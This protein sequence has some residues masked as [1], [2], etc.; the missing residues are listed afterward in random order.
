MKGNPTILDCKII[1]RMVQ[2][3]TFSG[4]TKSHIIIEQSYPSVITKKISLGNDLFVTSSI[5]D[6]TR[7][8]ATHP[9]TK[10]AW[11]LTD[12]TNTG[13]GVDQATDNK[14]SNLNKLNVSCRVNDTGI[15]TIVAPANIEQLATSPSGNTITDLGT[16][17]AN[18][19]ID[20]TPSVT[21]TGIPAGNLYPIGTT[22]ITYTV[23][24]FAGNVGVPAIQ[25]VTI[26]DPAPTT[27]RLR[28][29]PGTYENDIFTVAGELINDD[30]GKG[31]PGQTVTFEGTGIGVVSTNPTSPLPDAITSGFTVT[32]PLGIQIDEVSSDYILRLGQNARI[33]IPSEPIFVTLSLQGMGTDSFLVEVTNSTLH[34]FQ[35]TGLGQGDNTGLFVLTDPGGIKSIKIL[36][37]SAGKAGITQVVTR[38]LDQ[39]IIINEGFDFTTSTPYPTPLSFAEGTFFSVAKANSAAVD[40]LEVVASF[41]GAP[42]YLA[43]ESENCISPTGIIT[44]APCTEDQDGITPLLENVRRYSIFTNTAGGYG[45]ANDAG[46]TADTG[47]GTVVVL[48]AAGNDNDNDGLCNDWEGAAPAGVPINGNVNNRYNLVGSDPNQKDIYV[49]LDYMTGHD[50]F[51]AGAANDG[52]D[53]VIDKYLTGGY[54][55]D[56]HVDKG[57][58]LTHATPTTMWSGFNTLKASNFG[59]A[60]ER[61]TGQGGAT[62]AQTLTA[63][64]QAYRYVIFAHS[65]GGASGVAEVRG[66]DVIIALGSGWTENNG[67][68]A[69][70]EGSRQEIAGTFMHELGHLLNL[71]HGGPKYLLTDVTQTT[72][73]DSSTNCKPNHDSVMSYSLQ[74][75]K[76][77]GT[78]NWKLDYSNGGLG[79]AAGL[80]ESTLLETAGNLI[81]STIP[82]DNVYRYFMWGTPVAGLPQIY[83]SQQSQASSPSNIN[84]AGD[85]DGVYLSTVA[86]DINNLGFAGCN[87]AS[88]S[89]S[90]YKNYAEWTN[91][92][93]NFRQG[94]SGQIDG[95]N[96]GNDQQEIDSAILTQL[97]ILSAYHQGTSPWNAA[98]FLSANGGS[99]IPIK[100]AVFNGENAPILQDGDGDN[101]PDVSVKYIVYRASGEQIANGDLDLDLGHWHADYPSLRGAVNRGD[102]YIQ[103]IVSDLPGDLVHT[104]TVDPNT[105]SDSIAVGNQPYRTNDGK[106]MSF[107]FTLT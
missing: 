59:T 46:A 25:T 58:A 94:P 11:K 89:T 14:Q 66:N 64:A 83:L 29:I 1:A 69:G 93:F 9:I 101:I 71:Q 8:A 36:S 78:T 48:C 13:F 57:D 77:I 106:L 28:V 35:A 85:T 55:I 79:P 102:Y 26:V 33:D 23:S 76:I 98:S 22:T 87:T 5:Q 75:P 103:I 84:W 96:D 37:V 50:P 53:D 38:N 21:I 3:G 12:F 99:N 42:A 54:N 43:S 17:T 82:N 41:G 16:Y 62:V 10:V 90:Y 2:G 104:I 44:A 19:D 7:I 52:I 67:G 27:V 100:A 105:D 73:A 20:P 81:D 70:T 30:T 60:A 97:D 107:K 91:L 15:P 49:E 68:H 92:D 24:D 72:I 56:L 39:F 74:T 95:A 86:K 6:F 51:L 4:A 32:D 65:V 45:A 40:D 61:T 80:R 18:D 63:K 47:L 34:T 31:I 88:I